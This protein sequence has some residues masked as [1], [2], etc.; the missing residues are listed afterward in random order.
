M[1]AK[2]IALRIV[3]H[4][5]I[6]AINRQTEVL[7]VTSEFAVLHVIQGSQVMGLRA[8]QTALSAARLMQLAV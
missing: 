6:N 3:V 5:E 7:Y 2:Q 1:N 8:F 4:M